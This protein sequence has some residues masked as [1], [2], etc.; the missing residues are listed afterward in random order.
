MIRPQ[1]QA[2]MSAHS[3]EQ[4]GWRGSALFQEKTLKLARGRQSEA[5][6]GTLTTAH[7]MYQRTLNDGCA[8]LR[9]AVSLDTYQKGLV[10]CVQWNEMSSVQTP[11]RGLWTRCTR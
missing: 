5:C 11:A 8:G 6:A 7:S 1:M 2:R 9:W 4:S 3:A 10:F